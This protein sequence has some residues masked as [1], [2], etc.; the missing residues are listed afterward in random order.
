ML[1]YQA[2]TKW[3]LM[4]SQEFLQYAEL[5]GKGHS[6]FLGLSLDYNRN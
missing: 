3:Q 6:D 2:A 4:R 1:L 5:L